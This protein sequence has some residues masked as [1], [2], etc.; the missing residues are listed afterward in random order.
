M[1]RIPFLRRAVFGWGLSISL[2]IGITTFCSAQAT[3]KLAL[4]PELLVTDA[5]SDTRM[6]G[7]TTLQAAFE[8]RASATFPGRI[9]R[10]GPDDMIAPD[11][12]VLVL[13]PTITAARVTREVTAGIIDKYEAVVVGDL[14]LLD[15]WTNANLYSATRMVAA[16]VEI[17]R[18]GAAKRDELI[19]QAF[20]AAC[21]RWMEACL[22]QLKDK[23]APFVLDAPTLAV[24]G[25]PKGGVWPFGR[26][27][28]VKK[29]ATLKGQGHYAKVVD[30]ESR[31]A[32]IQDVADPSRR[33]GP[34][35][36]Y[37]LTVVDK[38]AER[39]EPTVALK[40]RGIAPRLPEG[41]TTPSLEPDAF[42]GLFN[43]YISQ[44]GGL[45]MLPVERGSERAKAGLLRLHDHIARHSQLTTGNALSL[46]QREVAE[47]ARQSPDRV[48]EMGVLGG[49]HGT[50]KKADGQ[51]EHYYR[52]R[53]GAVLS[54]RVG[55]DESARF[56][57]VAFVDHEEELAQVE[58]AGVRELD[59]GAAWFTVCRNA[60]IRL[61]GKVQTKLLELP[62]SDVEIKEGTVD[63][64]R[65]AQWKGSA[66]SR[67]APLRWLRPVGEVKDQKGASLGLLF[68]PQ[69]PSKG[70]LNAAGLGAEKIAPGDVL[71]F[72]GSAAQDPMVSMGSLEFIG[73][74]EWLPESRW[75]APMAAGALMVPGGCRFL[76]DGADIGTRL[77]LNGAAFARRSEG[78]STSFTGQWRVRL[79]VGSEPQPSWK[80]GLQT[81]H[82]QR[83]EKPAEVLQPLDMDAWAFE[84]VIDSFKKL[85]S[86]AAQKNLNQAL[87]ATSPE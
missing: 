61:A 9:M 27:R 65:A 31:Y 67:F 82:T 75:L 62:A 86:S 59:T 39:P 30:V 48:A 37:S 14:S 57:M 20:E 5:S 42:L 45:R 23:A 35:E 56:P 41:V 71:R 26:D 46:E 43:N 72:S 11:E 77:V 60:V 32:T 85:S 38:P 16:S 34:G 51:V 87:R 79:Q 8:Q 7:Q 74:P 70:F 13:V 64:S 3:V 76:L 19:R 73:A 49:Y 4:A 1:L 80:T 52:I 28:G 50:R 83:L 17:G 44:A 22:T 58:Q 53:L 84:Y 40:W 6:P 66:P 68:V 29:G 78:N 15:P 24:A 63:A 25:L 47:A 2:S 21:S 18:S 36:R 33:I 12:R 54:T 55:T 69:N 81:D 10:L